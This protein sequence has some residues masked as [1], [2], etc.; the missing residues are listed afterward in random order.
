MRRFTVIVSV[1]IL[2]LM[3]AVPGFAQETTTDQAIANS[4]QSAVKTAIEAVGP[5]VVRIDVTRTVDV[6]SPFDDFF[7]D[8][9][10]KRFFNYPTPKNEQQEQR[11]LGSGVVIMFGGEKLVLTNAHVINQATSIKVTSV[12]GKKMDAE[13]IGQDQKLDVAV[14]RLSENTESIAVAKLGTS[15]DVEVGD[16]AIAIGN[17]IGLSYTVTLGIISAVGRDIAKP[18]GVG[19]YDNLIQ[20]DAA[21][22]PGNSGG[23]LVNAA[24]EVVGINTAI[25][26]Q[27]GSGIT[28]EGINFAIAVDAIKEVLN[29]LVTTGQVTRAWL[30]VY[31]QDVSSAMADKF[32]VEAGGGV[33]VSD[34]VDAS[35]AE[36]AGVESGDV[37]LSVDGE[38]VGSTD[39]LINVISFKE[40]GA[41]VEL[42]I[43]REKTTIH[44]DVELGERP[45]EEELYGGT[46]SKTSEEGE[47][48]VG[49]FGLSV[50]AVTEEIAGQLGL[51]STR[52]VVIIAIESGSRASW[53]DLQEGD[54]I[55]EIDLV[56]ISSVDDWNNMVE[57]ME[58]DSNPLFTIFRGGATRFITLEQ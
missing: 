54:V 48:A 37:I 52:G 26:R 23:P 36:D 19:R 24:G 8:P 18:D 21:I 58:D 38:P 31:I 42:E 25:A 28:I 51:H 15:A 50:S 3:L 17:P 6:D 44:L 49:K 34:I 22:N 11:A 12:D 27:S 30:G 47:K 39:E 9:F 57:E 41:V 14:L 45:G 20:T 53:V 43:V 16:W 32:G 1:A 55:L 4:Q 13:V 7:D 2:V 5:A 40:V 56:P 35:P 46:E 29:Q 33:L 10:F